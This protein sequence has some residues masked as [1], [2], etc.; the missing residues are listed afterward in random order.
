MSLVRWRFAA[1]LG[2]LG[3]LVEASS[4]LLLELSKTAAA[5]ASALSYLVLIFAVPYLAIT[6]HEQ[7]W[8]ST[9]ATLAVAWLIMLLASFPAVFLVT[10]LSASRGDTY[11]L[12]GHTSDYLLI[13]GPAG[14]AALALLSFVLGGMAR[15]AIRA[16]AA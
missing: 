9:S 2:L 11:F 14:A 7:W 6:R 5:A 10:W 3:A 8:L 13:G 1:S 4:L 15:L 12:V 16:P